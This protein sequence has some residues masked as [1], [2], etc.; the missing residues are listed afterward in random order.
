MA[1]PD[2]D[3]MR[4]FDPATGLD[5]HPFYASARALGPVVPGPF[6]GHQLVTWEAAEKA[7]RHPEIF[8]S[9]M[10][11]VDLGQSVPLIPLQVDPPD[12]VKYRRLLDPI[13]APKK[14]N[15]LEE[16][17]TTMVNELIDEVID[18]G[19]CDFTTALSVPFPSQVFLRLLGL[20]LSELNMFLEMKTKILHPV[21]TD[22]DEMRAY[23]V[24]ASRAVESYFAEQ[25]AFRKQHP[26]DDIVSLFLAAEVDGAKMSDT[27]ILGILYL[28]IIAGLDT[29]TDTLE[30]FFAFLAQHPEHRQQLVEDPSLIPAAVEELLRF[31]TPVTGVSRVAKV[32]TEVM[33]CPIAKG[34]S[35]GVNIG[36]ANTDP[37]AFSHADEVDFSRIPKHFAFGGGVHR[38]LG[39][40]LAR[41]ELRTVLREWHRRIPNYRIKPGTELKVSVMLRQFEALPLLFD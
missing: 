3:P 24:E 15:L 40:H 2:Y 5:P 8:S 32:D 20:P 34:S 35:V 7:L 41:L 23:Q 10:E 9:S 26:A 6:G 17:L 21:G 22:L 27:E 29:V 14:V 33:G 12:H 1:T 25:L 39:S 37:L 18:K 16:E 28:F 30:C 13:F 19:E 38:C 31:E 4:M 36:S 11:A